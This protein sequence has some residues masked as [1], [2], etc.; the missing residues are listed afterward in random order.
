MTFGSFACSQAEKAQ[1]AVNTDDTFFSLEDFFAA[2]QA[3][4]EKLNMSLD[5]TIRINDKEENQLVSNIDICEMST[6]GFP[7]KILRISMG[8]S[9]N[10]RQG[11]WG[12]PPLLD[13]SFAMATYQRTKGGAAI[14]M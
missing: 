10:F 8:W 2:E 12:V 4:L 3:R 11:N 1:A 6:G 13:R 9:N 5:K 14:F 7:L